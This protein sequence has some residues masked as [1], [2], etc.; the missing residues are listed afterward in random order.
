MFDN[1]RTLLFAI[2]G[3]ALSFASLAAV[4]DADDAS[5]PYHGIVDRNVF[6]LKPP[7]APS[8]PVDPTPK[9]QP[10]K[11]FLTGITTVLGRKIALMKATIPDKPSEGNKAGAPKEQSFM[12]GEKERDGDIEV[13]SIDDKARTVRVSNF[14]T[15]QT[16]DFDNNG[17]KLAAGP[18]P[19][20]GGIPAPQAI[21][22]SFPQPGN[23]G[24]PHSLPTRTLRV[25]P[26]SGNPL[27]AAIQSGVNPTFASSGSPSFGINASPSQGGVSAAQ[28]Q[29]SPEE[30]IVMM[31]LQREQN[32]NNP[33]FPPLPPTVLSSSGSST[34]QQQSGQNQNLLPPRAP[35][36]PPLPGRP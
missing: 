29:I 14:G 19:A 26:G 27:G 18:A 32:K 24:V 33:N 23:P 25:Q 13:L 12:L 16:V 31:E 34:P 35:S 36:L 6:A 15:E 20:P 2:C 21:P 30:Q 1:G 5:N 28:P 8:A 4:P 9:V 10:P 17:V 22:G 11:I 3:I 7:P